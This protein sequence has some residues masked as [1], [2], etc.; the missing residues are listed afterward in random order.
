MPLNLHKIISGIALL[1][2][3]PCIIASQIGNIQFKH[4]NSTQGLSDN[5]VE[6]VFQDS[7][8]F[9]W[10]GTHNGL[11]RFN[12][13]EFEEFRFNLKDSLSI[14][15]NFV[16]NIFEDSH[17]NIWVSSFG[18]TKYTYKTGAFKRYFSIPDNETTI[19]NN[20]TRSIFEDF[21]GEVYMASPHGIA[22]YNNKADNFIRLKT[23]TSNYNYTCFA[24]QQKDQIWVGTDGHGLLLYNKKDGSLLKVKG[25]GAACKRIKSLLFT[26]NH[27]LWVGTWNNGIQVFNTQSMQVE[28]SF[29]HTQ[30]KVNSIAGDEIACLFRDSRNNIWIGHYN[31]G[32]S[33]YLPQTNEFRCFKPVAYDPYSIPS[34]TIVSIFEDSFH[35]LWFGTH[36]GGLAY[37]NFNTHTFRHFNQIPLKPNWLNFGVVNSF[38]EDNNKQIW[39]GTDGGGLYSFSPRTEVFKEYSFQNGLNTLSI[40]GIINA[41]NNKLYTAGWKGS[42][43]EINTQNGLVVK[44]VKSSNSALNSNIKSISTDQ[45]QNIWLSTHDASGINI[46][47]PIQQT[48]YNP[49]YPDI[50]DTQ[51]LKVGFSSYIFHDSKKRIW[52][53]S[54]TGLYM[55]DKKYHSFNNVIS[56]STSLSSDYVYTIFEDKHQRL[57]V[58]TMNG[59]DLIKENEHTIS[60]EHYSEKF[61][62]PTNIKSILEDDAYNLWLA[63]TNKIVKFNPQTKSIISYFA[64]GNF[65]ERASFKSSSNE[66]FFGSNNGFYMFNPDSL[67]SN[68]SLPK[69]FITDFFVNNKIQKSN[70]NEIG[71]E[72]AVIG[73][74]VLKLKHNQTNIAIRF[75]APAFNG[76]AQNQYK[77]KLENF[78]KEWIYAGSERKAIYSNLSPGS[79]VFKVQACNS[80]GIWNEDGAQ[81]KIIISPPFWKNTWF[82]LT[83]LVIIAFL[84]YLVFKLRVASIERKNRRLK[85]MV[86]IRTDEVLKGKAAVARRNDQRA[87]VK[88]KGTRS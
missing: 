86:R 58:A 55:F 67:K 53:C 56:D 15:G 44:Q 71:L 50:Y 78:D 79:Y 84:V 80:D 5:S 17:S 73:V 13:V 7:K 66:M 72:Q 68:P 69:V 74:N 75:V 83:F 10:F 29:T 28:K 60:F 61:G 34:N 63:S 85:E 38:A 59:L 27:L 12:G 82:Q 19:T 40:L 32:L 37:F 77:Y 24:Q 4:F 48:Y 30:N 20:V 21:D 6:S 16:S 41:G 31:C 39:I 70:S 76:N 57:W 22:I 42:L 9:L 23:A 49:N 25:L 11:N 46:Y 54:Y 35:N 51:L 33:V 65:N 64:V 18:I 14:P 88:A 47:N 36:G 3:F 87:F 81:L 2:G 8:G 1:I 26:S 43:C 45:Y 62:L 52:V